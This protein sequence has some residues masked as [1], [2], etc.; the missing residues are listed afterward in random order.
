MRIYLASTTLGMSKMKRAEAMAIAKPKYFLETFYQGEN[1]CD[2]VLRD[3]GDVDRF[4][5]DSGAFSFLTG[6]EA[7]NK[8]KLETYVYKYTDYVKSRGIKNFVEMDID[9]ITGLSYVEDL[10]REIEKEVGAQCIP[11]WHKSRGVK[12][13]EEICERYKYVAIGGFAIRELRR[14]EYP[15][16][17][18]LVQYARKRNVKVHGLGFTQTNGL[19]SWP[20]FSVDSSTYTKAGGRGRQLYTF[21]GDGMKYKRIDG[22]GKKVL[23]GDMIAHNLIEWSKYQKYMDSKK[24]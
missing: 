13:F 24:W 14:K 4:I 22:Q 7:F 11:V 18:K 21:T 9:S 17:L 23:A 19:E 5:L 1:T 6:T 3:A 20:F 2:K 10:R 8:N 16:V 15:A 12:K